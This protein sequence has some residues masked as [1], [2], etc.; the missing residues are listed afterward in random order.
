MNTRSTFLCIS[1]VCAFLQ[2]VAAFA[3]K[4][5]PDNPAPRADAQIDV[6]QRYYS[7][8]WMGDG[9]PGTQYLQLQD[10]CT[11]KPHTPPNCVKVSYSPG[12]TGWAGIYWQNKPNNWGEEPGEDFS[13]EGFKF[14]TF[15][16]RGETGSEIV[17]FKVGGIQTGG[18]PYRDSFEKT[19]G[20][21]SLT[22]DWKQYR[23]ALSGTNLS[24]IIGVFCF[25]VA[26]TA[27]PKGLIF[28]LDDIRYE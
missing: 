17:E 22:K 14:V 15:W 21:Q 1:F 27:N 8:G 23:I 9:K 12:P 25:S 3:Q 5:G 7:S 2:P 20:K 6:V 10:A 4:I 19:M 11:D 24:S 18:K 16:A 28:Y 13:K 26:G